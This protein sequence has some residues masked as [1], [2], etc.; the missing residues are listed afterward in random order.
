MTSYDFISLEVCKCLSITHSRILSTV[1]EAG[2]FNKSSS[3]RVLAG[4]ITTLVTHRDANWNYKTTPQQRLG[5]REVTYARVKGLD[6]SG[7]INLACWTVGPKDDW[8]EWARLVDDEAFNWFNVR[9]RFNEIEGYDLNISA[10]YTTYAQPVAENH[11]TS[12]PVKIEYAKCREKS[13][14]ETVNSCE[15]FG[16]GICEGIN[17]GNSIGMGAAP[18]R[19]INLRGGLRPQHTLSLPPA[20]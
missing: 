17:S 15:E 10:P 13:L 1:P 12:G 16:F 4:R 2:G 11:G 19:R 5:S 18:N 9:R 3:M 8:D 7:A 6:G 20:I 14:I